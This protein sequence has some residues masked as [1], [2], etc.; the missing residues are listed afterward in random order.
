LEAVASE[1][2]KKMA[3]KWTSHRFRRP[4]ESALTRQP[5]VYDKAG[6]EHYNIISALIKS[7]RDSDPELQF[8]YLA[9]ML[10]GGDDPYSLQEG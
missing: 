1:Y 7:I 3:R 6:E 8:Y 9:R 4:L 5:I 2:W 10:Q